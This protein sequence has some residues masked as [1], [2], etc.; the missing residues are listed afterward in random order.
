[1]NKINF[2]KKIFFVLALTV[3]VFLSYNF[4]IEDKP[5]LYLI[6]DSTMA[7]KLL[8][9]NPERGWGQLF[10]NFFN[11]NVVIEN[12]AKNGRST[13]SFIDQGLWKAVYDKLKPGDYV[14]I[15]FGHNDSKISDTTRYAEP[16]TA[17]KQNLIRYVNDSRAKGAFPIL[18]TPVNRRKFDDD[19]KF[20]DQHG[21]YPG[22]VREVAKSLNVPLI[23]LHA[24]S[25]ELFSKLGAEGTKNLF[26]MS[27]P[28]K[29]YKALPDGKV[30]NTHFTRRGAIIIAQMVVD[31]IKELKLP[32]VKMLK[33]NYKH[34]EIA[35]GK[36]VALDYF[37]NH[38][39]KKDATGKEYQYHY[40]WEDKENSGFSKLGNIIEN[41]GATLYEIHNAPVKDELKNTSIYIIVDPD[42]PAETAQ[43]NYIQE[44]SIEEIAN[45]VKDGGVLVLMGNDK[46]N[47]EFEHLNKLSERF[48]IHFNEVSLNKVDGKN[49]DMG[50]FDLFPNHPLFEGIKKIYLKEISTF[51]L[52][53]PAQSVLSRGDEII[54]ASSNY[55][56]GFVF[57]VG[58]PWLY[59]EYIDHR[60]LPEDFQN[61]KAA[62]NL[63]NWLLSKAAVVKN[64]N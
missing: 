17:Y 39:L 45:W 12:H 35:K 22:V 60:K 32:I 25:L 20:V 49:Y 56:K 43:P 7:D 31:G 16:H 24:K 40:I 11:D 37:Y 30:D 59:N 8:D 2:M 36:V 47:S 55:G 5:T 26:I 50:K 64:Y 53:E 28:P 48:G 63:F 54:M 13:K 46:G 42:T 52:K 29:T 4:F 58:D 14:F 34:S 6:G 61:Y 15:Q 44:N 38:E 3:S 10:P 23:D 51:S 57:A 1:M 9:D 62:E 27:V 33:P 41:F 19:G 18:I 21:D